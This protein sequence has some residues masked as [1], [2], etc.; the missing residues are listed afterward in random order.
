MTKLNE[1]MVNILQEELNIISDFIIKVMSDLSLKIKFNNDYLDYNSCSA[2]QKRYVDVLSLIVISNIFSKY[3][4]LKNGLL[5]IVMIDELFIY[6]D[7]ES[8]QL[9]I[10][11]L[12]SLI[13]DNI[14]I[15]THENLFASSFDSV[16]NVSLN[17]SRNSVYGFLKRG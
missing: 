2:G 13:T 6:F 3:H 7:D 12:D 5:G 9:A 14:L 10:S 15:I 16:V 11:L 8:L 17:D 4:N 1:N